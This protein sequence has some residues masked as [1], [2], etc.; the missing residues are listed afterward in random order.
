MV[1][2]A[3]LVKEVARTVVSRTKEKE[4]EKPNCDKCAEFQK[5]K[6]DIEDK[7]ATDT[8]VLLTKLRSV[9][10]Q[11]R[12]HMNKRKELENMVKNSKKTIKE[13]NTKIILLQANKTTADSL[14]NIRF[15]Q[16]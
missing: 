16:P 4:T 9:T 10:E 5:V 15:P 3:L 14:S 2:P 1:T 13:L 8:G 7:Y 6:E 12:F 11:R